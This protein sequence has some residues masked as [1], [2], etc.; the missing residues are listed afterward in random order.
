MYAKMAPTVAITAVNMAIWL[1]M[2]PPATPWWPSAACCAACSSSWSCGPWTWNP[3]P[4]MSISVRC[5]VVRDE[6]EGQAGGVAMAF[7]RHF[8]PRRSQRGCEGVA[9]EC[10]LDLGD[11]R[12]LRQRRR[13]RIELGTADDPGPLRILAQADGFL[14]RGRAFRAGSLPILLSRHDDV[15]PARQRTEPGRQRVPG[16]APHDDRRAQR[17]ALEMRQVLRQVPGQATVAADD[18]VGGARVDQAQAHQTA[19]GALMAAWHWY[20]STSKSSYR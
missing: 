19:T 9:V 8:L 13:L 6:T 10:L 18:A 17:H 4:D 5:L 1:V 12:H 16:P 15:A 20:S 3:A 7:A 2:L 14:Q 11:L